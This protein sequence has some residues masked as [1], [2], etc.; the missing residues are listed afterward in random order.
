[1]QGALNGHEFKPLWVP[2]KS[3]P[4]G[5]GLQYQVQAAAYAAALAWVEKQDPTPIGINGAGLCICAAASGVGH[6][7][8]C[9]LGESRERRGGNL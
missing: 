5:H 4:F 7:D 6:A 2:F 1:M 8:F 3:G 9:P